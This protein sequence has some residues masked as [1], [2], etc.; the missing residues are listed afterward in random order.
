M[1]PMPTPDGEV[2]IETKPV[3]GAERRANK[4]LAAAGGNVENAIA[5][6]QDQLPTVVTRDEFEDAI[7]LLKGRPVENEG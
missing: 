2:T 1:P 4:A 5:W 7:A 3:S 6:L